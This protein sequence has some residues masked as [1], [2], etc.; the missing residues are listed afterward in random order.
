MSSDHHR[1]LLDPDNRQAD[2]ESSLEETSLNFQSLCDKAFR[3]GYR[4][5]PQLDTMSDDGEVF[6]NADTQS[7]VPSFYWP[8]TESRFNPPQQIDRHKEPSQTILSK[9]DPTVPGALSP[10]PSPTNIPSRPESAMGMG[11]IVHREENDEEA[12]VI[13]DRDGLMR[14]M[15]A[16]EATQRQLDLQRAVM[17]KMCTGVIGAS[18]QVTEVHLDES[19]SSSRCGTNKSQ[20]TGSSMEGEESEKQQQQQQ[21]QPLG[22]RPSTG[23]HTQP[24]PQRTK[25]AL[26]RKLSTLGIGRRK[27]ISSGNRDTVGFS[28]I[29]EAV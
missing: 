5:R 21:Q 6:L 27:T 12:G 2:E 18:S 16:A 14:V 10:Y 9:R 3:T 11:A 28:R 22:K 15:S 29:A 24:Q 26:I 13:I 8:K 4:P 17:E 20:K 7:R 23:E 1:Q 25:S 19:S